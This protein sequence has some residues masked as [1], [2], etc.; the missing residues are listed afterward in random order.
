MW[1]ECD[2]GTSIDAGVTE[3]TFAALGLV[4]ALHLFPFYVGVVGDYHLTDAFAG[5]DDKVFV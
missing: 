5:V 3:G 1:W 4:D 2:A